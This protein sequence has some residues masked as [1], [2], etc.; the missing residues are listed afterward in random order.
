MY[1]N[2]QHDMWKVKI[3]ELSKKKRHPHLD[4]IKGKVK[5]TS[6][7]RRAILSFYNVKYLMISR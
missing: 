1:Q 4:E 2:H 3:K 6:R 7:N 5:Q